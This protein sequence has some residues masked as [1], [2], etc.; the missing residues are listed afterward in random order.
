LDKKK[1][2]IQTIGKYV[3]CLSVCHE[4]MFGR[5]KRQL[6]VSHPYPFNLFWALKGDEKFFETT[7]KTKEVQQD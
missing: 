3:C 1:R 2:R 6:G 5:V 4:K 7:Y